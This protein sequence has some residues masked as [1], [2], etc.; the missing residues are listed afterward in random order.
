MAPEENKAI[1]EA[2]IRGLIDGWAEAFR[3]K[4]TDGIMSIY[5]RE[6]VS[7]DLVPPLRYVGADEFRKAWEETFAFFQG[8]IEYE[9]HDRNITTSEDVAFGHSLN[10]LSGTMKNGQKTDYWH[11]WTAHF[12]KIDGKWLVTH[13][14][15]SLPADVE[16][17]K[18]VMDLK[19]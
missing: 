19:P 11:R 1:D 3:A 16:S 18:A 13:E 5:A 4:D 7:F 9:I 14:H 10:R 17:G 2:E 6:I 8:P 12:R 15:V